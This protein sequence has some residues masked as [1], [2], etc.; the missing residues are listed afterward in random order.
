MVTVFI[1]YGGSNGR[2]IGLELR[3]YLIES[4]NGMNPFLAG[5]GSPDI[6]AGQ[7]LNS[8]IDEK[9][10]E[11]HVMVPIC[12]LKLMF[13]KYARR[14]IVTAIDQGTLIIPFM[15]D[16]RKL[17]ERL[18]DVWAPIRYKPQNVNASFPDLY[19][20]IQ[21][22]LLVRVNDYFVRDL[23]TNPRTGIPPAIVRHVGRQR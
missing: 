12:D 20:A 10:T 21:N 7:D 5:K 16:G 2:E 19:T 1:C 9:L 18:K 4:C 23:G 13:S 11:A 6:A 15:M 14:E 8:V 17:P 3:R 22:A